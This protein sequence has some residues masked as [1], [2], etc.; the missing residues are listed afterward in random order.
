MESG[1][2][3]ALAILTGNGILVEASKEDDKGKCSTPFF[4][5]MI[6]VDA[7]GIPGVMNKVAYFPPISKDREQVS[8][9]ILFPGDVQDFENEMQAHNVS[10]PYAENSFE[11]T[12]ALLQLRY[13]RSGIFLIR[14]ARLIDHVYASY[15]NFVICSG[16]DMGGAVRYNPNGTA[17][18]H[19]LALLEFTSDALQRIAGVKVKLQLPIELIGFSKGVLPLNQLVTELAEASLPEPRPVSRDPTLSALK[20]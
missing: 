5:N 6:V 19:L 1:E 11:R 20:N 9:V 2:T 4:D 14:P 3:Q 7:F 15:E 10:R 18:K 8:N 16:K 12:G 17:C 13:P